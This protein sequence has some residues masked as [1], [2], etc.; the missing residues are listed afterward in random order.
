MVCTCQYGN[1]RYEK[2]YNAQYKGMNQVGK[3]VSSEDRLIVSADQRYLYLSLFL[4]LPFNADDRLVHNR[5]PHLDCLDQTVITGSTIFP[6][7]INF[8]VIPSQLR[9]PTCIDQRYV[10]TIVFIRSRTVTIFA[11]MRD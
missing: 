2:R 5:H 11:N 1:Q 6:A 10:C 4:M 3:C 9:P 7:A 8:R